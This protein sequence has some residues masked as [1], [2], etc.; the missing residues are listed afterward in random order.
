MFVL[1][2]DIRLNKRQLK[3]I[4]SDPEKSADA[5]NLVYVND[6]QEG[7]ERVRK[8]RGFVYRIGS[9]KISDRYQLERIRRLVIPPA[10]EN[11]WICRLENGH[12]QATG[13]DIKNRKQY[14]YHPLWSTVRN[15]T[16][17]Y[18]LYAFGNCIPKIRAGLKEDLALKGLPQKKVLATMLCLMERTCIRVGNNFY[19]KLYGS[20]GLTTLKDQHV[21]ING[22]TMRFMFRGKKGVFQ[23]ISVNNRR[24][25]AIVRQCRDIPG[26][27]LFQYEDPDGTYR[28]VDSGM[29]NEYI[30]S[31]SGADFTAK[32]FRT[33]A[34]T[35]QALMAF[36]EVG[37][38]DSEKEMR[39]KIVQALDIVAKRLGNTRTVCR[40]YYVHPLIISLYENGKI[41]RYLDEAEEPCGPEDLA[42][43]EKLLLAILKKEAAGVIF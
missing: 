36:R 40:K 26:K 42:C 32:D 29:V 17:F 2:E 28:C 41:Q 23:N 12:L 27:E 43:E 13:T 24:L 11:V 33:W 37:G 6:R 16:K 15:H 39:S 3:S 19:E 18:R 14:R 4:I 25:A 7:I 34:G 35:V 22:S 10:W 21:K 5:V 8:G 31:L 1:A 20:F 38:F 9:K 30:R